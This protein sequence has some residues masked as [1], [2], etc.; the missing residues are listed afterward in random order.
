MRTNILCAG[1]FATLLL[2]GS[3]AVAQ[4]AFDVRTSDLS[5]IP[6]KVKLDVKN[7]TV[8]EVGEYVVCDPYFY[9]VERGKVGVFNVVLPAKFDDYEI[10]YIQLKENPGRAASDKLIDAR[11]WL[12]VSDN[13]RQ[14][15]NIEP[16]VKVRFLV[17]VRN[18]T[19]GKVTISKDPIIVNQ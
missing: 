13:M 7:F 11:K 10:V 1:F 4:E 9:L 6:D 2:L 14:N 5:Q 15:G 18:T 17:A 8:T 19:T 12:I 16:Y 3:S